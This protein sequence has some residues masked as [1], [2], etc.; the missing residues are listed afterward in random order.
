MRIIVRMTEVFGG[1]S[2]SIKV[3]K[4]II[5]KKLDGATQINSKVS[6]SKQNSNILIFS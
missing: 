1:D 5:D 2:R 6:I 4:E 3:I